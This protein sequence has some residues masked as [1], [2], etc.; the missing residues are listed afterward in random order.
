M[1]VRRGK[2]RD[3]VEWIRKRTG[4]FIAGKIQIRGENWWM[5]ST[6]MVGEREKNYKEVEAQVE[7]AR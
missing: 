6:Y 5:G 2:K 3:E 7:Q 4:K 1:T